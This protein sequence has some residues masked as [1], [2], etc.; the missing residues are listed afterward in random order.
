MIAWRAYI[1]SRSDESTES[2]FKAVT[3]D[4]E[5][6]ARHGETGSALLVLSA[7]NF[8]GQNVLRLEPAIST[9]AC[10]MSLRLPL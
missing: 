1:R 2:T 10:A 4:R 6:V 3:A 9:R 8:I 5:E 7:I